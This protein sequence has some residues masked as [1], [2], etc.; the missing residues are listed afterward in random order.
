[1]GKI[2]FFEEKD[3]CGHH[4]E[5]SGDCPDLMCFF[6]QCKS[7]RVT[8]GCFMI[9]ERPNYT[10]NQYCLRSGDYPD[11]HSLGPSES[12][13]SCRFIPTE[14]GSF[15][16]RLYERIEFGGQIMNLEDDCPSVMD[17][18]HIKDIFSCNVTDGNWLFYEDPNYSGRMYLIQPGE[19][20][21]FS[22]WGSRTARV[23]SIKRITND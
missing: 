4:H 1:M 15:N 8:S 14:Q 17:R 9:Y 19:Y 6:N 23:G 10:G 11:I 16:M 12:V 3:F 21:R 22:E 5:C 18:F 13:S 20:K 7:I 2:I